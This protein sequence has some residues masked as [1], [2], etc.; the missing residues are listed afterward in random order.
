MKSLVRRI[1]T[2]GNGFLLKTLFQERNQVSLV[3][4]MRSKVESSLKGCLH[5]EFMIYTKDQEECSASLYSKVGGNIS[6]SLLE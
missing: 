1:E 4:L 5:V 3:T 2:S 6:W